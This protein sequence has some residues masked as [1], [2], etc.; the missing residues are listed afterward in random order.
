M[1][2]IEQIKKV[3]DSYNEIDLVIVFGSILNEKRFN[4]DSDI[5]IAIAGKDIFS[6]DFLV[7]LNL[8]LSEKLKNEFDIVDLNKNSG[9]ILQQ[10]LCNGKKL[11]CRNSLL[12]A[13]L[14]KK[15]WYNQADMMPNVR[16]IWEYRRN[17]MLGVKNG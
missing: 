3:L 8:E 1:D 6:P 13:E 17:K 2:I 5:D 16:M 10:A 12:Y 14:I 4:K 15:M 9:V 11:I 7:E